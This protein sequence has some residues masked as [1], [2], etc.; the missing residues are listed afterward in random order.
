MNISYRVDQET[1]AHTGGPI[2]VL[3][4]NYRTSF[5]VEDLLKSLSS[6]PSRAHFIVSI[7]DNSC[8]DLEFESLQTLLSTYDKVFAAI[9]CA[10]SEKNLGYAGGNNAAWESLKK[11]LHSIAP[12]TVVIMNPDSRINS[13]S[14]GDLAKEIQAL[15]ESIFSAPTFTKE[16]LMSGQGAMHLWTGMTRQL[17]M[18]SLAS[19]REYLYP[20]GHFLALTSQLWERSGGFSDDF[21]LYCEEADLVMRLQE[22]I[23]PVSAAVSTTVVI[24]HSEGLSTK[25]SADGGSKS[26]ITYEHATRSRILLFRKHKQLRRNLILITAFRVLWA[27]RFLVQGRPLISKSILTGIYG[28]Y[29]WQRKNRL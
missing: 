26:L 21:F 16:G 13:G 22:Q 18:G 4:V 27:L 24:A 15:P 23:P 3:I 29:R 14:L 2:G 8:N 19:D 9:S 11:I 1:A 20:G 12:S 5:A 25:N 7:W 6:D 28:A 17:P 10:R